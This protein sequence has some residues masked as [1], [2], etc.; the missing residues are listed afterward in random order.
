LRRELDVLD[1]LGG[2]ISCHGTH[3]REDCALAD[4]AATTSTP[5][6]AMTLPHMTNS[7][8]SEFVPLDHR[9]DAPTDAHIMTASTVW[10]PN[11]SLMV[12]EY[13]FRF[14]FIILANT[15][16]TAHDAPSAKSRP[17]RSPAA[18]HGSD[19]HFS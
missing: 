4:V 18:S 2:P 7:I 3:L 12:T 17:P 15:T 10:P 16:I 1:A 13:T 8:R 5:S 6:I 14:Y 9:R 19:P 11:A